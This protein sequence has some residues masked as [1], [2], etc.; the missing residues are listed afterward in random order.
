MPIYKVKW[1]WNDRFEENIRQNWITWPMT[2]DFICSMRFSSTFAC[3]ILYS[4]VESCIGP[5]FWNSQKL[6]WYVTFRTYWNYVWDIVRRVSVSRFP[7]FRNLGCPSVWW[8]IWS[9]FIWYST[10]SLNGRNWRPGPDYVQIC[11]SAPTSKAG[12]PESG[13]MYIL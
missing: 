13:R 5:L 1:L 4:F 8:V 12:L 7:R 6:L 10:L 11:N 3:Q 2:Y 9:F